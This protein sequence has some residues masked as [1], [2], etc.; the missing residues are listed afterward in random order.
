VRP[1]GNETLLR[2]AARVHAT[3]V[4]GPWRRYALWVQGCTIR[5]PGCCNPEMFAAAGGDAIDVRALVAEI[6]A[7]RQRDAIEGITVL[8]GEPLEQIA[9]VTA[10]AR[11]VSS[12]GLG[13]IVFTGFTM[14]AASALPG[15]H[16][17][18]AGLDTLVAGPFDRTSLEAPHGRRFIGS[19]N[20][21]LAHRTSRYADASLWAGPRL[22]EVHV[23][24]AGGLRILGAP[25]AA[26]PLLRSLRR[27]G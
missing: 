25:E 26:A 16:E 8:G 14:P 9:A 1:S 22:A 20:Q 3:D 10:L 18:W 15:F 12:L 7:A 4:E 17:L 6:E 11:A 5:C 21:V 23:D 19:R 27:R 24:R 2:V 13:V